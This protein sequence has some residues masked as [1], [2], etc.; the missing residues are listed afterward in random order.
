[1]AQSGNRPFVR[2]YKYYEILEVSRNA[3]Q[4]EIRRAYLRLAKI[5]HPDVNPDAK[6]HEK[7]KKINEAYETLSDPTRRSSYDNSPAE[8]PVCWTH[9]VIRTT[10]IHWR[11]RHCGCKFDPSRVSEIIEQVEKAAIPE[12]R[13]NV[14]RIFQTTQCSWCRKFYTQPFLCPARKLRSNCISFDRLDKEERGRLLEDEKWWW[15]MAD[16]IQQVQDRGIMGKCRECGALNPNP[17]KSVCW[18]CGEDTLCCPHCQ[19]R[20][21]KLILRYNIEGEFW[22]CSNAACS[23]KF[24][25]R[26]KKQ[27][28]EP[29]ISQEFCPNCGKNLY[30]DA[31]LLLWR[32]KSCQRIYTYH[33]LQSKRTH[34]EA[35][36]KETKQTRP[37]AERSY[38]GK[39]QAEFTGAARKARA[40]T[41]KESGRSESGH[42]F[43]PDHV[44]YYRG[45]YPGRR[46]SR[47]IPGWLKPIIVITIL[48]MFGAVVWGLLGSEIADFFSN[49]ATGPSTG[50]SEPSPEEVVTSPEN[51]TDTSDTGEQTS[52]DNG[53]KQNNIIGGYYLGL[54]YTPEGVL[55]GSECYGEFIV[56]INN[57][58]AIDPSYNQLLT[59]L[60]QDRT[61]QFPYQYT[62]DVM[63]FYY[64]TAES[65]ID[66]EYISDIISG[67]SQLSA[68]RICADFAE[69]LHNEAEMA[70][71][72]CAYVSVELS[73]VGHALNA[74]QTTDRGLIY[75]DDTGK[76]GGYGPSNCD[77]AVDVQIGQQYIPISLFPESGWSDIWESIGTV[78]DILITW[79]GN[80]N[81]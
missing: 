25:F 38:K 73:G 20:G 50:I 18:H 59:F 72:R 21:Q 29:T 49:T 51:S 36:P 7:F 77:K 28:V 44:G 79:D 81:N 58:R 39:R 5:H 48:A 43:D 46:R 17:Q 54:V 80:W 68:P 33:D 55:G 61:D 24:T 12:R 71:I 3:A 40:A 69:R 41:G 4:D 16:M 11:C 23:K 56:L 76:V 13:R 70:G 35:E 64:G 66:L 15:R 19:K 63:E 78:T 65:H 75:I 6:A 30:Y 74:F 62:L 34:R 37:R 8:C 52:E 60:Q 67:I 10:E 27:V 1:M 9:E 53:D 14:L 32:C 45:E 42:P 26:P 47:G 31:T 2:A 22:K 57:E